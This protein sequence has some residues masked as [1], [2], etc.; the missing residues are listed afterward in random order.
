MW[1]VFFYRHEAS[2]CTSERYSQPLAVEG[3]VTWTRTNW[4]AS[5]KANSAAVIG[6]FRNEVAVKEDRLLSG[7]LTTE[8]ERS[9][10]R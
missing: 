10:S 2:D 9:K 4:E 5:N 8:L 7:G 6:L 3:W 1:Y